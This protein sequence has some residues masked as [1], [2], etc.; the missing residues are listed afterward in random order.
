MADEP[1]EVTLHPVAPR[2]KGNDGRPKPYVGPDRKDYEAFH[3]KTVGPQSDEFWGNVSI[4]S[5]HLLDRSRS[6]PADL[7]GSGCSRASRVG[8]PFQD[9]SHWRFR[10]R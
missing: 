6:N 9:H 3:A 5:L 10:E 4:A 7:L 8:P 2:M 1:T